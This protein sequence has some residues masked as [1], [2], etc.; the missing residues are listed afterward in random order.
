MRYGK[1]KQHE[2][3]WE[4]LSIFLKVLNYTVCIVAKGMEEILF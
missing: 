1:T 3:L 2:F 4:I